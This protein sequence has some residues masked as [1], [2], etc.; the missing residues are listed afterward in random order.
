MT[1]PPGPSGASGLPGASGARGASGASG[2][3]GYVFVPSIF[4]NIFADDSS[5]FTG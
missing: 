3:S 5:Q 4:T 2:A 1:G